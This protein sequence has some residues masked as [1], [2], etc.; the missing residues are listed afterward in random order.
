MMSARLASQCSRAPADVFA[1]SVAA[2]AMPS[3]EGSSERLP[4]T[5]KLVQTPTTKASAAAGTKK[6]TASATASATA[7]ASVTALATAS[8]SATA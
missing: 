7:T 1:A 3:G 8:A 4:Q 6:V 2:D 5:Q